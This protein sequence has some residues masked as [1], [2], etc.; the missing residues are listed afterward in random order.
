VFKSLRDDVANAEGEHEG[1]V[2]QND[3]L[4]KDIPAYD[5]LK[6]KFGELQKI[7]AENQ[8]ALPTEAELPAF[9]ETL[10]RKFKDSGVEVKSWTQ[11]KEVI[12]EKFTKVP[13]RLE[14]TGTFLQIKRFM[15]S[16]VQKADDP[17]QKDANPDDVRERERIVS[18]EGFALGDPKLRNREL[19]LTARFTAVTYRQDEV[20]QQQPAAPAAGTPIAPPPAGSTAPPMPTSTGSSATPAGAKAKTEDALQKGD[21]KDRNAAGVNEAKTPAGSGSDRL[22]GGL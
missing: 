14:I 1:K 17:N 21:A 7:V 5:K 2:G 12:V 18:I 22:K 6:T 9:F 15:A 10:N 13:V 3:K 19:I 11:D 20:K 16:L 4:G 8:K